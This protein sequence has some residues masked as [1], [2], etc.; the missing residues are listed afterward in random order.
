[1]LALRIRPLVVTAVLTGAA[2]VH[3]QEPLLEL[4]DPTGVWAVEGG[5]AVTVAPAARG[6]N[7]FHLSWD[8][9]AGQYD[10]VGLLRGHLL[11]VGWGKGAAG[12]MLARR[13]GE[14]WTGE[15]TTPA[16]SDLQLGTEAWPGAALAGEREITG[17]NPGGTAYRGRVSAEK[18]GDVQH[19]RW[20]VGDLQ[21]AGVGLELDADHLAIGFGTG[22]FGVIVYDLSTGDAVG[23]RWCSQADERVGVER[24][25]R[26]SRGPSGVWAVDGG[27][28][29][30]VRPAERGDR[31]YHCAWDTPGARYEGIGMLRHGRLIV[32]WGRDAAG[33]MVVQRDGERWIGE[34]VT[35]ARV[36][37]RLGVEVWAGAALEGAHDL[38]GLNPGATGYRGRVTVEGQGEV[39]R[40]TWTIGEGQQHEG[41]GLLLDADHLAIGF[42]AGQ[43][44]VIVYDLSG[45]DAVVGRWCTPRGERVELER[46]TRQAR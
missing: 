28:T 6:D 18:R 10:G 9:P 16:A 17:V 3:A 44:G 33:V 40:L 19:L 43:F 31:R 37:E 39:H 26:V 4:P 5:G 42:G 38:T 2:A 30:T 27:G 21:H 34:W 24:L 8:T 25:T 1:M 20:T 36:D 7:R 45:G 32:G 46:L 13:E 22:N 15:W 35:P 29:L 23:G 12:V 11:V 14:G 41:V